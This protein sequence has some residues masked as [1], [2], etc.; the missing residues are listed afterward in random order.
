MCLCFTFGCLAI[1]H[2]LQNCSEFLLYT[3]THIPIILIDRQ[4]TFERKTKIHL[5]HI[6]NR[7]SGSPLEW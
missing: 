1:N 3:N 5:V 4:E 6:W 2:M 7:S